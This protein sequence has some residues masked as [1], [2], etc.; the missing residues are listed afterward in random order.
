V[1]AEAFAGLYH[2]IFNEP[3]RAQVQAQV[4]RWLARFSVP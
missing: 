1:E 4:A 3:E 2:E